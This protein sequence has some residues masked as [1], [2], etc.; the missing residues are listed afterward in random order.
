M[1]RKK[2]IMFSCR[3]T[4][5]DAE[6]LEEF[7]ALAKSQGVLKQDR[8]RYMLREL[9]NRLS[10]NY[11]GH[12]RLD[13]EVGELTDEEIEEGETLIKNIQRMDNEWITDGYDRM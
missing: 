10:R 11:L 1:T 7:L 4:P 13:G 9:H 12:L 2:S 8:F 5:Q 6:Y 3:L